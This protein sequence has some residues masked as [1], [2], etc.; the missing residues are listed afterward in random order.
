MSKTYIGVLVLLIS[1]LLKG[2]GVEIGDEQITSFLLTGAEI[3][4]AIVALYG[5]YA[6]GGIT[7]F[8]A[9]K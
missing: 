6:A 1:S 2:A 3:V 5:R 8:G 9:K 7:V 4:G